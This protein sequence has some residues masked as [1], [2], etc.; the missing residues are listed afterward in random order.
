MLYLKIS[1]LVLTPICGGLFVKTREYFPSENSLVL[2]A[3]SLLIS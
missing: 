1:V 2:C 3:D